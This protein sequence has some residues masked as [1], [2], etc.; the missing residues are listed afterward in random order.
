MSANCTE[1]HIYAQIYKHMYIHVCICVCVQMYTWMHSCC[2]RSQPAGFIQIHT[3]ICTYRYTYTYI[4][5]IY[6]THIYIYLHTYF[7]YT[8]L[9]ASMRYAFLSAICL[10]SGGRAGL[11]GSNG[12]PS[13]EL[14]SARAPGLSILLHMECKRY[15]GMM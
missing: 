8:D 5:I 15:D 3:H 7:A 11:L 12:S 4:N 2:L 14:A 1:V 13:V 6:I 9:S 10:A